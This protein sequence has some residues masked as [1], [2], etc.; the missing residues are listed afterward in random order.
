MHDLQAVSVFGE[1]AGITS[2]TCF[3]RLKHTGTAGI[4]V[5]S[6]IRDRNRM[7]PAVPVACN[8]LL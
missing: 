5:L 1:V 3:W 2:I 7:V 4:R 6:V 8:V